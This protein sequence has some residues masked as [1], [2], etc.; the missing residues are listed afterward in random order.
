[1]TDI[2]AMEPLLPE[3]GNRELEDLALELAAKASGFAARL[4]PILQVTVGD[5]V[6]SM[7]C[8][9]SNLIEGHNTHPVDIDRALAGDYAAE[10]EKRDLQMEAR[11]HIEVQQ[12][13]DNGQMP[14]PLISPEGICWLHAE[15][16]RRMP[17]ALLFVENPETGERLPVVPGELRQHHVRVGRHV[18][19]EPDALPRLMA[20]FAAFYGGGQ[21]SKLQR[22]IAVGA[23]HHRLSWIHPFMD[24][25]GRVARMFSHAMLRELGVGSGLWSI[26]RGLA[27]ANDEYRQLLMAADA[28]RQGD[29][30]GRG[31]LT[32]SGLLRFCVFFLKSSIDQV[33]F[34][35]SLLEPSELMNRMEIWT[36]EEIRMKRLPKGSWPLLREAVVA[37]EYARGAASQL[38]GYQERQA[39]TVLNM[40]IQ[41]RLLV[42]PTTRAKVRLG[43]PPEILERWLPRLYP[44]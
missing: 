18:A 23:A 9:Y 4:H 12:I 3:P 28:P 31:N 14:V 37:G 8:Y 26:S 15:F 30:D 24:G 42:S 43:F 1:M 10:P 17:P 41:K 19:P 33:S 20:R 36:E 7:N 40:L 21:H 32:E 11:A 2:S 25:N 16:C 38:T 5:L 27:R 35:E 22:L 13:I 6:R 44:A 34:M 39:G 29:R